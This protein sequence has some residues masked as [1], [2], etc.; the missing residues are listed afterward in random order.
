M[1]SVHTALT[2]ITYSVGCVT[3]PY[4]SPVKL[5]GNRIE[6]FGAVVLN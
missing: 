4:A 1:Y 6:T 2:V 3:A 5:F